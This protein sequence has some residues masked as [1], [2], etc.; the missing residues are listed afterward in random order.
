MV[1]VNS[2][3]K[4]TNF[5]QLKGTSLKQKNIFNTIVVNVV[6]SKAIPG[7]AHAAFHQRSTELSPKS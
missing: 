7:S 6:F 4:S 1:F 3:L 2:K 5:S